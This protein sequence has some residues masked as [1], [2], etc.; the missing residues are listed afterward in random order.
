MFYII[1]ILVLLHGSLLSGT[2]AFPGAEG[3]GKYTKGG[4]SGVVYEV[5]NLD[6]SGP[7]SLR[8]GVDQYGART[9]VFRV[10]GTIHLESDL[11]IN[12]PNITIAGQTAPGDGI[13]I[14]GRPL[15]IG[16]NEIIIRH[17]R[18]RLGDQGDDDDSIWGRYRKNIII[19]HCSASW[20]VDEAMSLYAND[21]MTVQ[22][23]IISESLMRSHH[24]K[25]D[26]GY[27]GIWGG[28]DVSFHHNLFAHHTSRTP[29]MAGGQT[30]PTKNVDFRN[31]VIYN[32]G[33]NNIYG[34]EDGYINIV[35]NY[36]K[37]GPATK[38]SVK[39]RIADPDGS[40]K[41]YV[42]GNYMDGSP[43][44]TADNWSNN[45]S[46]TA[47]VYKSD[48]LF[49]Y[50][51][52]PEEPAEEAYELV[53]ALAGAVLPERDP[54][55]RRIIYETQHGTATYTGTGYP[56]RFSEFSGIIT[57][58]IDSQDEVGGW[59]VLESV[60]PPTD[61]DHDGMPDNWEAENALDP[62]DP[63]D[64]NNVDEY[65]YT[66]LENYLNSITRENLDIDRFVPDQFTVGQNYPN[67]FNPQ[68]AL[69]YELNQDGKLDIRIY[70]IL[71]REVDVLFEGY[72]NKGQHS[73]N[74]DG[75]G[76]SG[77]NVS[78]GIYLCVFRFEDETRM[79]K[80]QLLR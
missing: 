28:T 38:S 17:I 10:S 52:I 51:P 70:D 72:N 65:G 26:H 29:R 20:S 37:P 68:T 75:K 61:S 5:T 80:M 74:W 73:I 8:N 50:V 12:Y 78:S 54:V 9:I 56:S 42:D 67:P 49:P 30:A 44:V 32:W 55:D 36:Y 57:G 27:G 62:Q 48:T 40:G 69:N 18:F 41:W 66:M 64:R 24:E 7:G 77:I 6:D 76:H 53:L 31:N 3:A 71:G 16:A 34:G 46:G 13:C 1:S 59:P 14:A 45:A 4:R 23:C 33:F 79:V 63:E 15:Y 2:I 47:S 19:D 35:N 39:T 43:E 58:I 60:E 21:S 25:G 22:W 11:K